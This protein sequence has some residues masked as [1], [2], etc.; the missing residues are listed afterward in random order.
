[1]EETQSDEEVS[2]DHFF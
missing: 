2:E 1:V